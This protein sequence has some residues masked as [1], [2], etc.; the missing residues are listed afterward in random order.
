M[1]SAEI[2]AALGLSRSEWAHALNVAERTVMRWED[3]GAEPTGL[4]A[5]VM[6]GIGSALEEGCDAARVG[7]LIGMGIGSFIYYGLTNKIPKRKK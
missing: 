3:E 2:R 6:R 4:A 7:R 5:E 1:N